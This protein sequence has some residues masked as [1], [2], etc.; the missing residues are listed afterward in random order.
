[1]HSLPLLP[2]GFILVAMNAR[3]YAKDVSLDPDSINAHAS[4]NARPARTRI[5]LMG[6]S[7]YTY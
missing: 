4:S 1:M 6:K 5:L 7:T 3:A 2:F